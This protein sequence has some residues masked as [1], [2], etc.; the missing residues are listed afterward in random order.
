MSAVTIV[1]DR[2]RKRLADPLARL[3]SEHEGE[4]SAAAL[5]ADC[6]LRQVLRWTWA[7][8]MERATRPA[9][10]ALPLPLPPRPAG[11]PVAQ[12]RYALARWRFLSSWERR[13]ASDLEVQ[14]YPFAGGR[15]EEPAEVAQ[16]V[17][18]RCG[19]TAED[20]A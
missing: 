6:H 17:A 19:A 3:G 4:R 9:P 14:I 7:Q 18:H 15:R 16:R 8:L 12:L 10:V 20:A 5:M 13:F 1:I 2:D 11:D